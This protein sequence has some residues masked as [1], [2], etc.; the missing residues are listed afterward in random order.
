MTYDSVG[1]LTAKADF[2]GRTTTY[3]YDANNNWLKK[4]VPDA[5]FGTAST[6][7][8]TYTPVGRR[9]TMADVSG[10]TTWIYDQRD[11]VTSKL[12]PEGTLNYTYD[13][14]GDP[15]TIRSSNPKREGH[16]QLRC[17]TRQTYQQ[18]EDELRNQYNLG[19][20]PDRTVAAGEYRRIQVATKRSDRTVQSRD[21]CYASRQ[22][23]ARN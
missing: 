23:A 11:R 17:A 21:G 9:Q 12:T 7:S 16:P 4:K 8:F 3:Q 20:P 13:K 15:L 1:N 19:Y 22:V 6:V 10:T 18:I 2:N 5:A 14:A